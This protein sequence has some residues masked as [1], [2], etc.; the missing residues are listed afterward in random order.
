MEMGD[1]RAEP[2][3]VG[4]QFDERMPLGC[5]KDGAY[6]SPEFD[7]LAVLASSGQLFIRHRIRGRQGGAAKN[8]HA[9]GIDHRHKIP[10][11]AAAFDLHIVTRVDVVGAL[12]EF[13]VD[14]AR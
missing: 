13:D 1:Q 9:I 3:A 2:L 4:Q 14:A 7:P 8:S 12:A 11:P 5:R 6:G 10:R